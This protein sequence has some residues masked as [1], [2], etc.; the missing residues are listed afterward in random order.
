MKLFKKY[1]KKNE[2]EILVQNL[3]ISCLKNKWDKIYELAKNGEID[4]SLITKK[5]AFC[6]NSESKNSLVIFSVQG[7]ECSKNCLIDKTICGSFDSLLMQLFSKTL[8]YK[9][10]KFIELVLK[11]HAE[12][13]KRSK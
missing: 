1:K 4:R 11:I 2:N 12:L 8:P 10:N 6:F 5:C 9:E 3:Y 13:L 7:G